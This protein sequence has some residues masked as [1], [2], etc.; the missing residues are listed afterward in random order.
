MFTSYEEQMHVSLPIFL[1]LFSHLRSLRK[2]YLFALY[3]NFNNVYDLLIFI[4]DT[5]EVSSIIV[6]TNIY[7]D[8]QEHNV[9]Q[10]NRRDFITPAVSPARLFGLS[11]V[12]TK[13]NERL[14][15]HDLCMHL[16]FMG[17]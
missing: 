12:M 9:K 10:A 11:V 8:T 5:H 15:I 7:T 4:S 17:I 16:D 6:W 13:F 3:Y 1:F 14:I 2:Q